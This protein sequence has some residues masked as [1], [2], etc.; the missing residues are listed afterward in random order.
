M[1]SYFLTFNP[2]SLHLSTK[3]CKK[4]KLPHAVLAINPTWTLFLDRDGVINQK[5]EADY[6]RNPTQFVFIKNATK[7]IAAFSQVFGRIVVVTNQQGI[8]KGIMSEQDLQAIHEKMLQGV[9]KAGGK[10]DNIYFSPHLTSENSPMRKPNTGMAL[11]A[12]HDFPEIDFQKS[13]MVGDSPSDMEF[14][15]RLGMKTVLIAPQ[16]TVLL[17]DY[18]AKSLWDFCSREIHFPHINLVKKHPTHTEP[19]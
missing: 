13:V 4:L 1:N 19:T 6:V 7:A 12:Q 15:A 5:I 18:Q 10:I 9:K 16:K 14:G 11:Q 3:K 2:L 17:V 8:G